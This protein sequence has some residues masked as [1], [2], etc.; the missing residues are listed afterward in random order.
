MVISDFTYVAQPTFL[1]FLQA[2]L[3]LNFMVAIDFTGSNGNPNSPSSLHYIHPTTIL[4]TTPDRGASYPSVVS[5]KSM[6]PYELAIH[7]VGPVLEYYDSDKLFPTYGFGACA[8]GSTTTSHCFPLNGN[9]TQPEVYG[10]QGVME[11]Y[12]NAIRSLRFSGPTLFEFILEQAVKYGIEVEVMINS[13]SQQLKTERDKYLVL[14]IITDGEIHDMS[15][16]IRLIVKGADLPLSILIV[17]VGS[18]DF[19]NM[20]V[21]VGYEIPPLCNEIDPRRR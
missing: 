18:A 12:Q 8:Q 16:S 19:T 11:V 15:E 14:L 7:A 4:P 13:Y 5:Y 9:P 3:D 2:G 1:N 21:R 10:I 6:N 17:G 20:D